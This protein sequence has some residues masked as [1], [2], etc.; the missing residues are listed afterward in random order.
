M[1]APEAAQIL[2]ALARGIDPETGR[3]LGED[4]LLN[5]SHIVRALFLGANALKLHTPER[6]GHAERTRSRA[7][8]GG[9]A[10]AG[11]SWSVEEEAR[12]VAGFKDEKTA[13]ELAIAHD[14]KVGGIKARL[15]KLGL[16]DE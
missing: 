4:S 13:A 6:P 14:R 3:A 8:N 10:Q 1:I 11:K 9:R 12:L 5:N 15:T 2:E 7:E 16:F